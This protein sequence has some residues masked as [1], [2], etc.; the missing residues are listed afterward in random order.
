MWDVLSA[1]FDNTITNKKCLENVIKNTE[2][3]SILIFHD[4][5]KANKKLKYVLPKILDYY[6]AKNYSFKKIMV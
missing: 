3:G 1:D 6:A 5:V 2:S 4:S